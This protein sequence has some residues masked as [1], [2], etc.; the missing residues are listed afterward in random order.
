MT[1]SLCILLFVF[2]KSN[3]ILGRPVLITKSLGTHRIIKV[4]IS[5]KFD[6]LLCIK[7]WIKKKSVSNCF[8][9]SLRRPTIFFPLSLWIKCS[10]HIIKNCI[11]IQ[12]YKKAIKGKIGTW[13]CMYPIYVQ[14]IWYSSFR[15][16]P[17]YYVI[18]H[19]LLVVSYLNQNS[20]KFTFFN[21]VVNI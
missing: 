2:L 9:D 14:S 19:S 3:F 17:N 11:F 10:W 13:L 12:T 18:S 16:E 7:N 20:L 1:L 5:H 21:W 6:D 4:C 15:L 8:T